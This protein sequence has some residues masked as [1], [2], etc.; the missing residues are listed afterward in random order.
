MRPKSPLNV[1][2]F[3]LTFKTELHNWAPHVAQGCISPAGSFLLLLW[4]SFV[5]HIDLYS[6]KLLVCSDKNGWPVDVIDRNKP[7][8]AGQSV[9]VQQLWALMLD[10]HE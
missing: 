2:R 7:G 5:P 6:M 4:H 10:V 8:G 1:L 3:I 9:D